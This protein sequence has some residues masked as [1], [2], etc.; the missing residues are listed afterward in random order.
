[1][2][3]A[4]PASLPLPVLL[5]PA[6]LVERD[7]LGADRLAAS[8]CAASWA[9]IVRRAVPDGS[10][11][12][13]GPPPHD[14]GHERWLDA[15]LVMGGHPLAAFRATADA[16][17]RADWRV[18]PVHLHVGRDH[19]VLTDPAALA[20][21]VAQARALADSIVPLL[22][23]DGLALEVATPSRWYLRETDPRRP[24]RLRTRAL[25]AALGRSI[26]AWQPAGDDARRW[27]RLLNE[28]QMTWHAHPVNDA[29]AGQGLPAV[30]SL[31]IEGRCPS[32]TLAG[33]P[34]GRAAARIAAAS[35]APGGEGAEG[36]E[37]S[38]AAREG[39]TGTGAAPLRVE[40]PDGVAI[41]FD[42]RLLDAHLGGDPARWLDAWRALDAGVFAAIARAEPP[43]STG[44]R[45]VLAGDE[46]WR[47][48]RVAPR[49]DWRFWRRVDAAAPLGPPLGASAR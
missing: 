25:I 22:A 39:A 26:D 12:P 7:W 14:P 21:D 47:A 38:G 45:V 35:Q 41:V 15:R 1:V 49:A 17:G 42:R 44:A 11:G 16:T 5:L 28:I 27:R 4:V 8:A 24:L 31:W 29:R 20:L 32:P 6:A 18:D 2:P 30:N 3:N 19:L 9:A 13:D 48:L 36:E 23:D 46:G 34:G 40:G 10:A 33:S 43:W 37:A